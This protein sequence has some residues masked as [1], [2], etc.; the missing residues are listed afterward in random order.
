MTGPVPGR[1]FAGYDVQSE[2]GRGG[3][4]RVFLVVNPH[5]GRREA[6]KV[7]NLDA[8]G[9]FAARFAA[10]ARTI[11]SLDHPG[12]VTVY[13][14]GITDDR[15]WFT[16]QYLQGRDLSGIGRLPVPQVAEIARQA[17]EALDYAHARGVVHRDVKPGNLMVTRR[18]DGEIDRVTVLDFGIARLAGATSLT[19][20]GSFVGTLAYA[21]PETAGPHGSGP[22]AD[23]YSLACTAYELLTGRPPYAG[24]SPAALLHAHLH[25][26]PPSISAADPALAYLDEVF[27]RALAKD[28]AQRYPSCREFAA[29]LAGHGR[30]TRR[31]T[32]VGPVPGLTEPP[33]PPAPPAASSRR[34]TA[35]LA[36]S[37]LTIVIGLGVII[38]AIVLATR[39]D[40]GGDPPAA[41]T[42]TVRV[43]PSTSAAPSEVWG[44][45]VSPEGRVVRFKNYDS[46][47]ALLAAAATHGYDDS[48]GHVTFTSGCAAVAH[49]TGTSATDFGY[50]AAAGETRAQAS[51]SAV[52][53]SEQATG[54]TSA[55]VST[56][57]VG[58]ELS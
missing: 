29:A 55:A 58:D 22:A 9:D 8:D 46:T 21:A 50:Y 18:P 42:S 41:A 38:A 40:G 6:L 35:T 17:G 31:H 37:A 2:L 7:L 4:G 23:Q 26:E 27:A 44:L 19:A 43:T 52:T 1:A 49:A 57:C 47:S 12:I 32:R 45:V 20:A 14:H 25:G 11:A 5:L 39:D 24:Q 56:L 53:R 13:H 16:M 36:L 10:E 30:P 3:M 34:S 15:P 33:L 54:R 28:P 48:W 51:Q